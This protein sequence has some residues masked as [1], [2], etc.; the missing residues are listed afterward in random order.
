M[1]P[2]TN[3]NAK[4][5]TFVSDSI[6]NAAATRGGNPNILSVMKTSKT[7][8][9]CAVKS[10]QIIDDERGYAVDQWHALSEKGNFYGFAQQGTGE[11]EEAHGFAAEARGEGLH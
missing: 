10:R 9:A 4:L 2:G 3:P 5:I 7:L 6:M 1:V 11:S 8:V